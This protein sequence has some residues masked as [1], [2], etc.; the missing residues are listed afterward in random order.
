MA[1]PWPAR[2]LATRSALADKLLEAKINSALT[3]HISVAIAPMT[4][5]GT[6][7][8]GSL[9]DKAEQ[10]VGGFAGVR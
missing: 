2:S 1:A 10:V 4:L 8:S 5:M 6:S 9:R 7:T 3:E